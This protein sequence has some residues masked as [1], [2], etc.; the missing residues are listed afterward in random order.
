MPRRI[1]VM[2]LARL[3]D[4]VQT[5]PLLRRL[6]HSYPG[7]RI[8][9]LA[10]RR[11]E[12]LQALGP[13]VE[14][15]WGLN[16]LELAKQT[17]GELPA[18]YDYTQNL[19][20]E[21]RSRNFD[22][23]F[24]LNFSRP[25]LLL[26]YLLGAPAKG[27]RPVAGGRE[28]FREPW[29]ALVYS[30][31]HA[32]PFNRLHLTDVFRHL[33]PPPVSEPEFPWPEP[34]RGEPLLALQL[35]TR[36]AKRTWP[37]KHFTRLAALLVERLGARLYLLGSAAE[38]PLG[39]KLTASLPPRYRE[40]LVNLQGRTSLKILAERLKETHLLVSGD[41]GTLHLA[42]HLGVRTIALFLGPA[43]CFE[44]GPYGPGHY[45]FQAEPPC[46]P[47]LEAGES[48][49][50]PI[51]LEMVPPEPVAQMVLALLDEAPL[52]VGSAL[53]VNTRIYRTVLE[54]FGV[55]Y[56]ALGDGP[57]RFADLVGLAYR[58]AGA[59]LVRSPASPLAPPAQ[60]PGAATREAVH[61]LLA[62][63]KNGANPE[64]LT[65][66]VAAALKPLWAY[67][68]E[69]ARQAPWGKG[70]GEAQDLFQQMKSAFMAQLEN[71]VT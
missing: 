43:S 66:A 56:E 60:P 68:A 71:W 6:R 13:P 22:L 70:E 26:T 10:D 8:S 16:F 12:E 55:D 38:R 59:G 62:T 34:G 65:P 5:W 42:T 63:L 40:R 32:R 28:F 47:C 7:A 21:L 36:H 2:Q 52:P 45:V 4:L 69:L 29:L 15:F 61:L 19:L 23:I 64:G 9:L 20:A 46:H 25:A 14:E 27:Y 67:R 51:C 57:P 48:C 35:A 44:T 53:P 58:R 41:T 54:P 49:A 39:E 50:E 11:L 18:A 24:N 17:L 31:V 30:L 3:G 1:L 37:L 33:A